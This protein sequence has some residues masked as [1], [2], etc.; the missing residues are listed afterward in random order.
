[1][2]DSDEAPR[3]ALTFSHTLALGPFGL[4]SLKNG[5]LN[6]VTLTLYRFWGKTEVRR[7]VWDGVRM[8]DE[9]FEYTGR[10]AELF[11]GFLLAVG[12][13]GLPFL[14]VVFGAQF[15]PPWVA[16][17]GITTSYVVIGYLVGFGAFTAFRYAASR[18][19]WRGVRFRLR[20]SA[21]DYALTA[22][23]LSIVQW[24]TVGWFTPSKDWML[25]GK[26][27]GGLSFGDRTFGWS[28]ARK[29]GLYGPFTLAWM[30]VAVAYIGGSIA[31]VAVLVAA[32]GGGEGPPEAPSAEL[33]LGLYATGFVIALFVAAAFAPYRAALMRAVAEGL[34][35][36]EAR[37]RLK[38]G[39][40]D[41]I[42]LTVFNV[43]L[44]L[45]TLGFAAPFLQAR[46]ARFLISRLESKGEAALSSARQTSAGPRQGEGLADAFGLSPI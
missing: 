43:A 45:L 11:I 44:L 19:S 35:L 21:N 3:E 41:M 39:A 2:D 32:S 28:E 37:F 26:L 42:G 8:N 33:L 16:A 12:V 24:I 1:M 7:R 6:L 20:G 38:L 18:T 4:L 22:F 40:G 9:P 34:R 25:A 23:G 30:G 14:I 5:L 17:V 46:T 36:D 10:G 13:V 27:W 31:L 29:V 15:L